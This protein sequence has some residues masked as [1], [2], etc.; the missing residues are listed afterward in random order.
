MGAL[1]NTITPELAEWIG[2]QRVFFVATAPLAGDGHVNCSPKGMDGLRVLGPS[3]VA[4][5]DL[6][7]SGIE[8]VAHLRENGRIVIMFCAFE[9]PAKIVRLHGKGR[10]VMPEDEGFAGLRGK[11]ADGA[12]ARCIIEVAV[13]RIGDSCG[14]GVPIF[15][16]VGERDT[17]TKW[18]D[19]KG[20]EELEKYRRK[21]N[22]TSI[23]GLRGI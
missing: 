8:T 6:T 3:A 19:S 21:K 12:G 18:L 2:R 7:G 9:G 22:A 13:T 10:V 23:D 4:Y 5:L 1:H 15:K 14:F 17:L 16:V 11:F 20:E